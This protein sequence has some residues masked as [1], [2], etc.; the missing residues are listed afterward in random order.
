[1]VHQL[2]QIPE[3]VLAI[4]SYLPDKAD[5]KCFLLLC[6]ATWNILVGETWKEIRDPW[7]LSALLPNDVKLLGPGAKETKVRA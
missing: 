6:R 2:F 4:L 1:M 3:L 5:Q 7:R